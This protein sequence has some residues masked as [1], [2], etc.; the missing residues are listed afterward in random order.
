[1]DSRHANLLAI[2]KWSLA[3]Q[4]DG[5]ETSS[6]SGM[7]EDDRAFLTAAL[8]EAIKDEPSRLEVELEVM[9]GLVMWGLG[10]IEAIDRI[11]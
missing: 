2:L 7:S 8:S 4:S 11:P 1:M 9:F 5:T 3:Q 10:D 6:F